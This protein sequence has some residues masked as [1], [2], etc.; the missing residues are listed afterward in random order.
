MEDEL[1]VGFDIFEY[2]TYP[3]RGIGRYE[4][5]LVEALVSLPD[6]S[7][8][9]L[10]CSSSGFESLRNEL[11]SDKLFYQRA[12]L[13]L[14]QRKLLWMT[15]NL[16]RVPLDRVVGPS[17]VFHAPDFVGPFLRRGPLVITVHDMA[18][19]LFPETRTWRNSLFFKAS[20]A[21]SAR[22]AVRV[23]TDSA[24]IRDDLCAMFPGLTE[25]AVSIHLAP[26]AH[27]RAVPDEALC[28]TLKTRIGLS[29]NFVLAVG[30]LEPRKNY[31]TLFSAFAT[32]IATEDDWREVKLVVVGKKGWGYQEIFSA[33]QQLGLSGHIIWVDSLADVELCQLYVHCLAF[34]MPSLY[35]GFGLPVL[36]AMACG[37][38]A[39][40]SATP[41]LMEVAGSAALA[42]DP[43]KVEDL[44]GALRVI[45]SDSQKREQLRSRGQARA[46]EFTWEKTARSTLEVYAD[47]IREW[48]TAHGVVDGKRSP[49]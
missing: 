39:V 5:Q 13:S 41:A 35:E 19:W 20:F 46:R 24:S 11:S 37:S 3:F 43:L 8:V 16:A 6:I 30:T 48:N 15:A 33:V 25:K 12:P 40:I 38:A 36:E 14:R 4:R 23:I 28:R 22:H 7:E 21:A 49:I 18:P 17:D 32:L 47:A 44:V 29:G 9:R 27:Y 26:S 2:V 31:P 1:R 10:F 42:V 45:A 34:V